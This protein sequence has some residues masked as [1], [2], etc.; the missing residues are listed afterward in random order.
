MSKYFWSQFSRF[1][2]FLDVSFFSRIKL[3]SY[4]LLVFCVDLLK[5]KLTISFNELNYFF[6]WTSSRPPLSPP[7]N[8]Y[9][10]VSTR[11]FFFWVYWGIYRSTDSANSFSCRQKRWFRLQ[12]LDSTFFWRGQHTKTKNS[13]LTKQKRASKADASVHDEKNKTR[14]RRSLSRSHL[15]N[16]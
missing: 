15:N 5:M 11:I 3:D 4:I 1:V 6:Q 7:K 2:L 8:K 14:K 10:S 12:T 16:R 9:P 13:L